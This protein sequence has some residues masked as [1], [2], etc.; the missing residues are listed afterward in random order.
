M[1]PPTRPTRIATVAR[2]PLA[3]TVVS[4]RYLWRTTPLHRSE[5][6]GSAIDLPE[7]WDRAGESPDRQCLADGVGQMMH[8]RYTVWIS[9]S[10]MTPAA[11][12]REVAANLDRTSPE[13]ATFHKVRGRRGPVADGDEY[14]VRMPGPWDGPVRAERPEPNVLR[15]LTL[16]GHLEAGQIEFRA[17]TEGDQLRFDIE[18]WTRAG[19]RLADLLY[20]RVRLAKE[21]QLNM[22]T[23]FCLRTAALGGGRPR[24]GITVVSRALPW[25]SDASNPF[26]EN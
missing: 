22:W 10:T 16:K 9:G 4:W 23:H 1:T 7:G 20:N 17:A 2:W 25:P 8:R 14:V 21:I 15:L 3:L 13:I 11:L 26:R 6:D 5:E 19:D 24:N 12:M 18:S